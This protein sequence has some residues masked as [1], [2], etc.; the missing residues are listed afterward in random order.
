MGKENRSF[1]D[2]VGRAKLILF[3]AIVVIVVIPLTVGALTMQTKHARAWPLVA[4]ICTI[5]S[6]LLSRRATKLMKC[7]KCRRSLA[8]IFFGSFATMSDPYLIT[9]CPFCG[10]KLSEGSRNE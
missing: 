6:F 5:V 8:K 1:H 9:T 10:H 2:K 4:V 7:P 3:S